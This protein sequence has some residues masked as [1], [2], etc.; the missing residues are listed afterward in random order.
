MIMSAMVTVPN[1]KSRGRRADA[2]FGGKIPPAGARQA[3]DR[4]RQ[5][6]GRWTRRGG[7]IPPVAEAS[8]RRGAGGHPS[9]VVPGLG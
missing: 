5:A 1:A 6:G 3:P 2:P 9:T 7:D 4:R 8:I